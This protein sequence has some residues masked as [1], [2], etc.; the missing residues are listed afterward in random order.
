MAA[1]PI[2]GMSLLNLENKTRQVSYIL[3]NHICIPHLTVE[4]PF[5]VV[6]CSTATEN[7][8]RTRSW[9]TMHQMRTQMSRNGFTFLEVQFIDF[10]LGYSL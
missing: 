2:Q 4:S 5:F 7:R 6:F 3:K 1:V 10:I 8:P 9:I